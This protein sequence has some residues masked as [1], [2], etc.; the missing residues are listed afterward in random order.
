[1]DYENEARQLNRARDLFAS[2]QDFAVPRAYTEISTRRILVMDYLPGVHLDRFL[3]GDPTEMERTRFGTLILRS[4]MRLFYQAR[5]VYS[6]D[7][8]GNYIFMRD[9]RLGLIDFGCSR[10]FSDE[11]WDFCRRA[12]RAVRLGGDSLRA[13][14]RRS[15]T[16]SETGAV[17]DRYITGVEELNEWSQRPIRTVGPFDF[18]D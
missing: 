4:S 2:D 8:P 7:S 3:A 13:A 1:T 6:D 17:S 14:I 18:G 5:L 9:G 16:G 15:A 11:E 12:H 10:L